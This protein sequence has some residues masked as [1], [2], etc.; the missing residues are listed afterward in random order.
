[1]QRLNEQMAAMERAWENG[2]FENLA[3]LAAWLKGSGDTAGFDAFT[4]PAQL[5]EQLAKARNEAEPP[6]L[7]RSYA[8]LPADR[9][10]C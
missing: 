1:M 4:G 10:P 2:D 5:L 9:D 7:W 6:L 3:S 8:S